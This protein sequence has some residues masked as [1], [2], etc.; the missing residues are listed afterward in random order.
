[1]NGN[2][3][4]EAESKIASL[5][6]ERK[7]QEKSIVVLTEKLASKSADKSKIMSEI[8]QYKRDQEALITAYRSE[9]ER[10]IQCNEEIKMKYRSEHDENKKLIEEVELLKTYIEKLK[11]SIKDKVRGKANMNNNNNNNNSN[12]SNLSRQNNT[13]VSVH[14]DGQRGI[15]N[16]NDDGDGGARMAAGCSEID[17]NR[18]VGIKRFVKLFS[19]NCC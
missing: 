10:G 14:L 5:I 15:I 4:V 6:E 8:S 9:I 11:S 16:N 19:K 3:F 17:G 1:M 12:N 7:E 18:V 13:L 2:A